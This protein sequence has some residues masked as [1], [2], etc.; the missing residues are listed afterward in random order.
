MEDKMIG[1]KC[2]KTILSLLPAL[3]VILC[4]CQARTP[5]RIP[6]ENID[7]GSGTQS[8]SFAIFADIHDDTAKLDEAIH[9]LGPDVKFVIVLGDLIQGEQPDPTDFAVEFERVKELELYKLGDRYIPIPGNHD[10]WG[11]GGGVKPIFDNYFSSVYDKLATNLSGWKKQPVVSSTYLQN[12]AFDYG[13]YHFVCLDF[14]ARDDSNPKDWT[15]NFTVNGIPCTYTKPKY[16]FGYAR[17]NNETKQWL[18]AC[19]QNYNAGDNVILFSHHPPVFDVQGSGTCDVTIDSRPTQPN[20]PFNF[21]VKDENSFGFNET[22]YNGLVGLLNS[23]PDLHYWWFAGH[24]HSMNLKWQDTQIT[25]AIPVEVIASVAPLSWV[26]LPQEIT[27]QSLVG[28]ITLTNIQ[29]NPEQTLNNA[30]TITTGNNTNGQIT[31]VTVHESTGKQSGVPPV[32]VDFIAT[33]SQ[34]T[35]GGS[36]TLMWNVTGAT[37]TSIDQGIGNV[38]AAG[39]K[40]VSPSTS[41]TYTLTANNSAG[42]VTKSAKVDVQTAPVTPPVIVAFT[43]NPN[44]ITPGGSSTLMWNVTGATSISIDQGIGNVPAAGTKAVSPSTSTTYTLTAANATG[45]VSSSTTV[46]IKSITP[47][48]ITVI[49]PN[50]GESWQDGDTR[51]ITWTSSGIS[52]NVSIELSKDGGATWTTIMPATANDGNEPWLVPSVMTTQARIRI[53]GNNVS[54]VSDANFTI[55]SSATGAGGVTPIGGPFHE[56]FF[57]WEGKPQPVFIGAPIAVGNVTAINYDWGNGGPQMWGVGSDYFLARWTG[58]VDFPAGNYIFKARVDDGIRLWVDGNLLIDQWK[59]QVVT[60]FTATRS[61]SAG[62]HEI[63]VEYFERMGVAICQVSWQK[64]P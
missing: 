44:I 53:S 31:I 12:F 38:P 61:L 55:I 62:K 34:I 63:K 36:A 54:D 28:T 22:E 19:L 29:L 52:G 41:T 40:A 47:I 30:Y 25:P 21:E 14:C 3:A 23:Y 45:T 27:I 42:M 57:S 35:G 6:V 18:Q 8:F 10:I 1:R 5:P 64:Q 43:A 51:T 46:D 48:Q 60:E 32:I 13:N 4:A 20:Q 15:I 9:S 26:Q 59:P 11:C 7:I 33:P 39:T 24:Y 50:G 37:S 16:Q 2:I 56:E 49:S 58:S 17:A